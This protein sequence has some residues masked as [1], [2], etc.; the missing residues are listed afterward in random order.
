MSSGCLDQHMHASIRII[1]LGLAKTS[2]I[3]VSRMPPAC[4]STSQIIVGVTSALGGGSCWALKQ[5]AMGSSLSFFTTFYLVQKQ[6]SPQRGP[7]VGREEG[8]TTNKESTRESTRAASQ[9]TPINVAPPSK[10]PPSR[11]RPP[12]SPRTW[13]HTYIKTNN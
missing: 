9:P 4:L 3:T 11:H 12:Q 1:I 7:C 8:R 13:S 10:S 2:D 6:P 5:Y